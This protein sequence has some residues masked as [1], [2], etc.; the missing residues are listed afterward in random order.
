MLGGVWDVGDGQGEAFCGLVDA[1][2]GDVAR[3]C[4]VSKEMGDVSG[5]GTDDEVV[6]ALALVG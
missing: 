6:E 3:A 2:F 4:G 5:V 1:P